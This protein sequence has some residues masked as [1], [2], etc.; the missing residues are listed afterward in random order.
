V[1]AVDAGGALKAREQL[2]GY[3]ALQRLLD[4]RTALKRERD[5]P[6]EALTT[7]RT[8]FADRHE[9][10][11]HARNRREA[12]QGEQGSLQP[13]VEALREE[14]E[15][16]RKQKSQVTNMKQLSAVVSELDHVESQLKAREDRL[17]A[18]W[19]ELEGIDGDIATLG[20]ESQ[21]ERTLREEAE[22]AWDVGRKAAEAELAEVERELRNVQ[23]ELGEAGMARFKKLWASRKPNAVVPMDGT[24]CSACHADLR[25][26]LVQLVRTNEELQFCD[27][28]RRLLYDPEKFQPPA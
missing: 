9:R 2:A 19:Q 16:F 5:T 4:R 11:D 1:E 25:P 10:L 17:L 15:H 8:Q 13:E 22:A 28:C 27:H 23:H 7:L 12:L 3:I 6:P 20:E 14:R 26:S 18:I 21:E 24:A